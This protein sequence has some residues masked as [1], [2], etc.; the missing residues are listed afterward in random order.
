MRTF[1]GP[2]TPYGDAD[3]PEW[4]AADLGALNG[5]SNARGVLQVMRTLIARRRDRRGPTALAE[6]DRPGLRVQ[7]D[8][9][10]LVLGVPFRFG[11]G[12]GLTPTASVP[13]LPTAGSRSGAA[14]AARWS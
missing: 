11:I 10:D 12:Y 7:A 2:I 1:T 5:H 3:S 14:G 6:D 8:G 13:Y 9:V 4:R